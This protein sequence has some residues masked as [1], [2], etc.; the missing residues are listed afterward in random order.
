MGQDVMP[1]RP[2]ELLI[3]E[4]RPFLPKASPGPWYDEEG[5]STQT[6]EKS[7]AGDQGTGGV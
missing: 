7:S 5:L 2:A 1:P 4:V 6:G 3:L